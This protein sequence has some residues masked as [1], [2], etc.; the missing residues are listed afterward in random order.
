VPV[1]VKDEGQQRGRTAQQVAPLAGVAP[2][3]GPKTLEQA[4]IELGK[5]EALQRVATI[6]AAEKKAREEATR[7]VAQEKAKVI[8]T[9]A[10]AEAQ[11]LRDEAAQK[12]QAS[13]LAA[14]KSVEEM[15]LKQKEASRDIDRLRAI[16]EQRRQGDLVSGS[17]WKGT[18]ALNGRQTPGTMTIESRVKDKITGSM[19]HG[20]GIPYSFTGTVNGNSV[21]FTPSQGM[22]MDMEFN[23]VLNPATKTITGRCQNATFTVRLSDGNED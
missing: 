3:A 11:R 19:E 17:I 23:C 13:E 10:E 22:S 2:P 16:A 15:E 20:G 4:I 14:A 1:F 5:E 18:Y 8:Q 21:K 9:E 6:E 12:K 7:L